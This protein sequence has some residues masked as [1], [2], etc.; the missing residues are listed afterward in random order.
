M[1]VLRL[2]P[3]YCGLAAEFPYKTTWNPKRRP[4]PT[5]ASSKKRSTCLFFM[6]HASFCRVQRKI[7]EA[8]SSRSAA[9]RG[10][11]PGAQ[12]PVGQGAV[13]GE[14]HAL[15]DAPGDDGGGCRAEGPLEEP[16]PRSSGVEFTP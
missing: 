4:P 12:G 9:N 15:G 16:V 5:G 13:A 8:L 14:V 2:G 11:D 6:F 3:F 7:L 10:I 1:W